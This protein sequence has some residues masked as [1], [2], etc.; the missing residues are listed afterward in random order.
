MH[1]SIDTPAGSRHLRKG[2]EKHDVAALDRFDVVHKDVW[3]P[4]RKL[5]PGNRAQQ[6]VSRMLHN[7]QQDTRAREGAARGG[8]HSG[9]ASDLFAEL[10]HIGRAQQHHALSGLDEKLRPRQS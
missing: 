4:V 7:L 1:G 5:L 3:E 8:R 10:A 9:G 2:G 6:D